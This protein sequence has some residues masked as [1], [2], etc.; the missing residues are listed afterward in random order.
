METAQAIPSEES[1]HAPRTKRRAVLGR[2]NAPR[3]QNTRFLKVATSCKRA[4]KPLPMIANSDSSTNHAVATTPGTSQFLFSSSSLIPSGKKLLTDVS[5]SN[6]FTTP[7]PSE[8]VIE[9]Y[10]H[11]ILPY[12]KS[13]ASSQMQLC[14]SKHIFIKHYRP[15]LIRFV[16]AALTFS[17][18]SCTYKSVDSL[19]CTALRMLGFQ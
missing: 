1:D 14:A 15:Q 13:V 18:N 17:G 2:I 11:S 3:E 10:N 7:L 19:V 12:L 4:G 5:N 8:L 6:A 9:I 16:T